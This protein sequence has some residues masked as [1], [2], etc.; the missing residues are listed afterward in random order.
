MSDVGVGPR[1]A[2]RRAAPGHALAGRAALR[3]HEHA[4]HASHAE[5]APDPEG[6]AVESLEIGPPGDEYEQEA[7]RFADVARAQ[8]SS[9][10]GRPRPRAATAPVTAP[11]AANGTE[12]SAI[13]SRARPG[14]PLPPPALSRLSAVLAADLGRVRVRH[15]VEARRAARLL[16]ARA[17]TYG[18]QIWLSD[19]AQLTDLP[20]L[21]HEATH[22]VQQGPAGV[23]GRPVIQRDAGPGEGAPQPPP[24]SEADGSYPPPATVAYS[25]FTNITITP[26]GPERPLPE[27]SWQEHYFSV[28]AKHLLGERYDRR[29]CESFLATNTDVEVAGAR[30]VYPAFTIST[31]VAWRIV[32]HLLR[33]VAG[34]EDAPVW[35]RL[36]IS[37]ENT[38]ILYVGWFASALSQTLASPEFRQVV[39]DLPGWYTQPIALA[40]L[41]SLAGTVR[42]WALEALPLLRPSVA[43]GTVLT[44]AAEGLYTTLWPDVLA[45]DEIRIDEALFDDP[46]FR[47]FWGLAPVPAPQADGAPSRVD[48]PGDDANVSVSDAVQLIRFV[49]SQPALVD[50][51]VRGELTGAGV[52]GDVRTELWRRFQ[53]RTQVAGTATDMRMVDTLGDRN[54]PPFPSTLTHVPDLHRSEGWAASISST[55]VFRLN[56]VFGDVYDHLADAFGG[57]TY[58]FEVLRVPDSDVRRAADSNI[59]TVPQGE[60]DAVLGETARQPL[61]SGHQPR[62]RDVLG[63]HL[64]QEAGYLAADA[65][66]LAESAT[67]DLDPATI[68]VAV[69]TMIGSGIGVGAV[70]IAGVAAL[71]RLAGS[72]IRDFVGQVT[73]DRCE[74]EISFEDLGPG[75]YLVRGILDPRLDGDDEV[76]RYP[77]TAVVPIWIRTQED[78]AQRSL[79]SALTDTDQVQQ[80]LDIL[81]ELLRDPDLAPELRGMLED[82]RDRLRDTASPDAGRRLARLIRDYERESARADLSE[83]QRRPIVAQLEAMRRVMERR[84]ARIGTGGHGEILTVAFVPDTGTALQPLI[85]IFST[86]TPEEHSVVVDA[87]ELTSGRDAH[88]RGTGSHPDDPVIRRREA[89]LA[90]VEALFERYNAFGR[91]H[92]RLQIPDTPGG[93]TGRQFTIR[94]EADPTAIAMSTVE[95]VANAAAI[96]ALVAAPFTGGASLAL[97]V[98]I[99]MV[100]AVPAAYRLA[101]QASADTLRFDDLST[102]LDVVDV[103]SSFAGPIGKVVSRGTRSGSAAL[104]VV[105]ATGRGIAIVGAG[106]DHLGLI[107]VNIHTLAEIR[108]VMNGPGS[109]SEKRAAIMMLLGG[110]LQANGMAAGSHLIGRAEQL[111]RSAQ[112]GVPEGPA[113]GEGTRTVTDGDVPR[114]GPEADSP[115]TTS[116]AAASPTGAEP[117]GPRGDADVDRRPPSA[118]DPSLASLLPPG[119][120]DGIGFRREQAGESNSVRVHFE[121]DAFGLVRS[122]DVVAGARATAADVRAHAGTIAQ[123]RRYQGFVGLVRITFDRV[124]AVLGGTRGQPHP[125]S[126]A[127]EAL[128]ELHKLPEVIRLRMGE[129]AAAVSTGSPHARDIEADI[130]NLQGQVDFYFDLFQNG[131]D[132]PRRGYVAALDAAAFARMR[133]QV[134]RRIRHPADADLGDRRAWNAQLT[135]RLDRAVESLERAGMLTDRDRGVIVDSLR[136]T[137]ADDGRVSRGTLEARVRRLERLAAGLGEHGEPRRDSRVD[138][139]TADLEELRQGFAA[140][141]SVE[142]L[143]RPVDHTPGVVATMTQELTA[144]QQALD[145]L[146]RFATMTPVEFGLAFERARS[147]VAR[148][149]E[150][151][152]ALGDPHIR[153]TETPGEWGRATRRPF[154]RFQDVEQTQVVA[155]AEGR[156]TE[157]LDRSLPEV[158]LERY[159]LSASELGGLGVRPALRSRLASFFRGF[160]RAHMSGPGFGSELLQGLWFAP[161][162]FNLRTQ[163]RGIEAVIRKAHDLGWTVDVA[164][165]A[166]GT[167]L[168]VPTAD[169]SVEVSV[170]DSITYEVQYSPTSDEP[171]SV[172]RITFEV[173]GRTGRQVT[174]SQNDFAGL[175][176]LGLSDADLAVL[177]GTTG[178]DGTSGPGQDIYDHLE[179]DRLPDD[180]EAAG[181]RPDRDPWPTPTDEL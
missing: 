96:A 166:Q 46:S 157:G 158:G 175:G 128:L 91:G 27:R 155:T 44:H 98:P 40:H 84:T 34:G 13:L 23:A 16:G 137:T 3:A 147:L 53:R 105:G 149:R 180:A 117:P 82:R 54:A 52:Q 62:A 67:E 37:R 30:S 90:A 140:G 136:A 76:R 59:E 171:G 94:V 167:R 165:R 161:D 65:R 9:P 48:G 119:V 11:T 173:G 138:Q 15:D 132:Q 160:H 80:E 73:R 174:I 63:H 162:T 127:F 38:E 51:L 55:H 108:A 68:A 92:L 58:R 113:V 85:E 74:E 103:L 35:E 124:A 153:G 112:P 18:S 179:R 83:L 41:Q 64:G 100:G 81:A 42:D 148:A 109:D 107:L 72:V 4:P 134:T 45:V 115:R 47:R 86:T 169:G 56:V 50:A 75:L 177:R 71:M 123:L 159:T 2:P 104:R 144:A 22:V 32:Q 21:A 93:T 43:L 49:H 24:L 150:R 164:I 28:Y 139:L 87:Y 17:F 121:T 57:F 135:Q 31:A 8:P 33:E 141:R 99:G 126:L 152:R 5:N 142:A 133:A 60:L 12:L 146:R 77:S 176:E 130:A 151:L 145:G 125:D 66:T 163:N 154:D 181:P 114:P 14:D 106:A 6:G 89:V 168:R 129:L 111:R 7:D 78:L 156:I 102:W 101:D 178:D 25:G 88:G 10:P 170:L 36:D 116:E 172:R 79:S 1:P 120:A 122:I 70:T 95:A 69:T 61:G 131:Y 26:T 97:M 118:P 19:P 143:P 29:Y 110:A 20:L 39:G